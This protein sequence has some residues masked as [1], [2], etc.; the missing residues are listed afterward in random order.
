MDDVRGYFLGPPH[1]T[2]SAAI[3]ANNQMTNGPVRAQMIYGPTLST[4]T[5]FAKFGIVLKWVN[6]NSGSPFI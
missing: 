5:N 6:V 1:G 2:T 3:I 4:K